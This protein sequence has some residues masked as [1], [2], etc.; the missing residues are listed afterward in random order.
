MNYDSHPQYDDISYMVRR[1]TPDIDDLCH[2]YTSRRHKYEKKANEE[3]FRCREDW[4]Q[5]IGPIERWGN[6]NPY[7]G[8]FASVVLPLCKPERLELVS[9]ILECEQTHFLLYLSLKHSTANQHIKFKDAFPYGNV[10]ESVSK[11]LLDAGSDNLVL[12]DTEYRT[13][14]PKTGTKQILSKML[15]E[16]LSIDK[17]CAEVVIQSWKEMVATTASRDNCNIFDNIEDYVEYRIIDTG[18]PFVDAIRRF[19]MG[20]TLTLE[21]EET[22]A[23]IVRPCFGALG[24]ANDYYSFDIEWEEFQETYRAD[25]S[26]TMTNAVWLYM[27][28]EK[29]SIDEAKSRVVQVV[30]GYEKEF[31]RSANGF[32][33]DTNRC[34]SHLREYL[35]SLAFQIPGNIV[36]RLRCPRYHPELCFDA[37]KLLS[38]EAD[39]NQ[40]LPGVKTSNS[41]PSNRSLVDLPDDSTND[42]KTKGRPQLS[43]EVSSTC[44]YEYIS[45]LPSKGFREAF[46]DVLNVWLALREST[47]KI[48]KTIS[49]KLHSASLIAISLDFVILIGQHFQIR[50]DYMNLV[51]DEYT[52]GKGFSEDLDEGEFSFPIVHAWH[53]SPD[54]VMRGMIQ[55]GKTSGSLS[56]PY[57]KTILERLYNTGRMEYTL[58]TSK[59]FQV[60]IYDNLEYAE[61]Q[62]GCEN[63][64]MR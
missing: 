22:I 36:W 33:V 50:D 18:A 47:L 43:S 46:F 5:Y 34:G 29:L 27:N 30:R 57:K 44:P 25:S 4:K 32:I 54:L 48:I 56:I 23:P 39:Q 12:S 16:L 9:Y 51:D 37:T 26:H 13:I 42:P 28:W 49:Q 35:R 62:V 60:R 31:Q 53:S 11:A 3:S 17:P 7:E 15:L 20:I 21:E 14:R 55:E 41:I 1:Q 6:C 61:K 45:S 10:L 8:H 38:T 63:W 52:S 59:E 24:L 2:D 40:L 19:G 58:Q 64:V